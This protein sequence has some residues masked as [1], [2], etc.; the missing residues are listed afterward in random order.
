MSRV[1]WGTGPDFAEAAEAL[2]IDTSQ[3]VLASVS[4]PTMVVF[5]TPDED[6]LPPVWRAEIERDTD[7]VLVVKGAPLRV[8]TPDQLSEGGK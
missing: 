5:F 7:S 3:I 4:E 1:E 8:E 6:G 2:G